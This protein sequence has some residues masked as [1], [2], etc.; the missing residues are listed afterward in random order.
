MK[1][2]SVLGTF[3]ASAIIL[4]IPF[5]LSC[6]QSGS[7]GDGAPIGDQGVEKSVNGPSPMCR[8][9]LSLPQTFSNSCSGGSNLSLCVMSTGNECGTGVCLFD[10]DGVDGM[11]AY[12]TATCDPKNAKSCPSKFACKREGCDEKFVCVR[13][14]PGDQYDGLIIGSEQLPAGTNDFTIRATASNSKGDY[15]I[16][17]SGSQV[18]L[19]QASGEWTALHEK[20]PALANLY[21]TKISVIDDVFYLYGATPYSSGDYRSVYRVEATDASI[22]PMPSQ[23]PGQA[24]NGKKTQDCQGQV[25]QVWKTPDGGLGIITLGSPRYAMY[26]RIGEKWTEEKVD[27]NTLEMAAKRA[28]RMSDG[29]YVADGSKDGRR[30]IFVSSDLKNWSGLALP[31]EAEV[32]AAFRMLKGFQKNDIWIGDYA[33][34]IFRWTGA[35]WIKESALN[36][37]DHSASVMKVKE[38]QYVVFSYSAGAGG[39]ALQNNCWR[40]LATIPVFDDA[41]AVDGKL[42][43]IQ[44][45]K[46]TI[47]DNMFVPEY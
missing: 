31:P 6:S 15:L 32:T 25:Y 14:E 26:K 10:R 23:Y 44:D 38:Q 40:N 33:G 42:A 21:F 1:A 17:N 16:I 35:T 12:C 24:C 11:S 37:G 34:T 27:L 47:Y 30:S 3:L 29:W 28:T 36:L 7:S 8:K 45:G 13:S 19:R 18:L 41:F 9:P 39:F 46:L 5:I 4:T 20:Q 22:V 2:K 43:S